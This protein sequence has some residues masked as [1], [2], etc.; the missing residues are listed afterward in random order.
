M[1][2]QISEMRQECGILHLDRAQVS[3]WKTHV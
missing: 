1:Y 3:T 2:V